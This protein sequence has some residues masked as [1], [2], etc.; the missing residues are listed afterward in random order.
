MPL[1]GAAAAAILSAVLMPPAAPRAS[2]PPPKR[3]PAT[4]CTSPG[5]STTSPP[6]CPRLSCGE[7]LLTLFPA[8]PTLST[9]ALVIPFHLCLTFVT[10]FG[11]GCGCRWVH[12]LCHPSGAE[13]KP[14][15]KR[16]FKECLFRLAILFHSS[17]LPFFFSL[18]LPS[19]LFSSAPLLRSSPSSES[20]PAPT[21]ADA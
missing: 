17:S 19:S 20:P 5:M 13:V 15:T 18:C 14:D 4:T 12:G 7:L 21:A 6:R 9:A 8:V 16:K 3:T 10:R 2:H 11:N 1:P